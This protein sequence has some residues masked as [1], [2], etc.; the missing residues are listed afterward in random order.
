MQS[1]SSLSTTFDK[2]N[3][4][5]LLCLQH[6]TK[7]YFQKYIYYMLNVELFIFKKMLY[8]LLY[9]L[10]DIMTF[11]AIM[12]SLKDKKKGYKKERKEK[13]PEMG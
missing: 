10:I 11:G 9:H 13:Y 7:T 2:N 5:N 4:L 6:L 8:C 3:N 12:G 1:Q